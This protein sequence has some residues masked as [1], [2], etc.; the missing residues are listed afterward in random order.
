MR[1]VLHG[2]LAIA[3]LASCL[4]AQSESVGTNSL[5]AGFAFGGLAGDYGNLQVPPIFLAFDR[6]VG[7]NFSLGL[8]VAYAGSS[9]DYADP[10]F[11][12]WTEDYSYLVVAARGEYHLNDVLNIKAPGL[13]TYAG[14]GIGVAAVSSS[15][16][17]F[18]TVNGPAGEFPAG[19]SA[20]G[21]Y[22]F[23]EIFIGTRYFFAPRWAVLGELGYGLGFLKIGISHTL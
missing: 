18:V 4:F 5:S 14:L 20:G 10:G 6:V 16:T 23:P 11:D 3:C 9:Y 13:D 17:N 21:S 19:Y 7:R 1:R 8:N 2:F 15:V 12:Y 22:I